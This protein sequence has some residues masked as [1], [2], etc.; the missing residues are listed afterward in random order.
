MPIQPAVDLVEV[1]LLRPEH[2]GKR[3][4][5]HVR[6]I[7]ADRRRGD[8]LVECVRLL[9]S[10]CEHALKGAPEER[11]LL[12]GRGLVQPQPYRLRLPRSE[13]QPVVCGSF[14]PGPLRVHGIG[15]PRNDAVVDAVFGERR[16]VRGAEETLRVG[17]VLGE[18]KFGGAL[19]GE[20]PLSESGVIGRDHA[21]PRWTL[22]PPE[23]RPLAAL[24]PGVAEPEGRQQVEGRLLRAP[25]MDGDLYQD[26][27]RGRLRVLHEDV[28]VAVAVEY[29]GIDELVLQVIPVALAVGLDEVVVWER[30]LRVPVEVLHVGVRRGVVEVVVVLLHVLAVVPLAVGQAKEPFFEDG[31]GTVPEAHGKTEVLG[32]VRDAGN[33]VLPPPVGAGPCLVVREV[34]P[35]VAVLPVILSHRPPLPFAQVGPPPTPGDTAGA[36][37]EHPLPLGCAGYKRCRCHAQARPSI[38]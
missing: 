14:G 8:V 33:P 15:P 4:P 37:L 24:L 32:I 5:H 3:L 22:R 10:L 26:I 11:A 7:G 17:L 1:V 27:L 18:E 23:G 6:R 12:R 30:G 29:P 25:V 28:E 13:G 16:G 38:T 21:G 34:G 31:I 19:A 35:G 20:I 2:A 9:H 36:D